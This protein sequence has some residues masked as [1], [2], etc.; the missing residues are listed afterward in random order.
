[1]ERAP[2]RPVPARPS[3]PVS[4]AEAAALVSA[5][6]P[7]LG[8]RDR[9]AL[10]LAGV[11]GMQRPQVALRLG[12]DADGLSELLARARKELRRTLAP[13]PGSGWCERAERLISDRIDGALAAGDEPRLDV[14]LRNCPRCVEHERR[15]VQATDALVAG[16]AP[17]PSVP[18]LIAPSVPQPDP[19]PEAEP[20]APPAAP[21]LAGVRSWSLLVAAVLVALAA[22][23]LALAGVLGALL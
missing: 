5:A 4:A 1:M 14:H 2:L 23:A 17:G 9:V 22:I 16:V 6:L 7:A 21:E 3:G 8:E 10:A 11:A 18:V 13:L 15:L 19:E 12:L 20:E